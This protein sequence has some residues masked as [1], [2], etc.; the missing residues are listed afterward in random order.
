MAS[1][2]IILDIHKNHKYNVS[3]YPFEDLES[4]WPELPEHSGLLKT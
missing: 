4:C 2:L 1:A 3:Y